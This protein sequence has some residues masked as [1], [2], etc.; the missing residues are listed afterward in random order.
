[1]IKINSFGVIGGDKR[2]VAMIDAIAQDG[3]TV[4]AAGFEKTGRNRT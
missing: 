2:Q 1:M 4:Y 3:Y